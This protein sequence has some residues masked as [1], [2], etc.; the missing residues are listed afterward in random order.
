MFQDLQS[1]NICQVTTKLLTPS[2]EKGITI[3]F[4]HWLSNPSTNETQSSL[5]SIS[6]HSDSRIFMLWV[7]YNM[8]FLPFLSMEPGVCI[9][10]WL[11]LCLLREVPKSRCCVAC[12]AQVS[13]PLLGSPLRLKVFCCH[14]VTSAANNFWPLCH[15]DRKNSSVHVS[16]TEV[17]AGFSL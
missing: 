9:Q 10:P 6:S 12:K 13:S 11:C 14:L 4:M 17:K 3:L 1:R 2:L 8:A 5:L 16:A 7:T 15:C